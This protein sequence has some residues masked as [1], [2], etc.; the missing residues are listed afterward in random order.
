MHP[1]AQFAKS[2]RDFCS[3]LESEPA[4]EAI[5]VQLA[6]RLL[7][8]LYFNALSLGPGDSS[9]GIVAERLSDDAWRAVY[10]RAGALPFN[11]Y[12][13]VFNPSNPDHEEPVKGDLADDFADI[14]RDVMAG[15]MLY[16]HGHGSE[17]IWEW[18][19]G[20]TSHWGRHAASALYALHTYASAHG[21]LP[22]A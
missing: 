13:V 21:C 6:I 3:W 16:D 18:H 20:F 9:S 5:E 10:Q 22:S 8:S 19:Q 14:Y 17:A 11:Y 12:P 2:A 4:A 7:A 15:L 1:S